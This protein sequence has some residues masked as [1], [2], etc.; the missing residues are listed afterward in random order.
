MT[1]EVS[2][3]PGKVGLPATQTAWAKVNLTLHVTGQRPDGYHLLDSLVVRLGI[4]D[5]L[6]VHADPVLK[7]EVDGP[8]AAG[9]PTDAR[10]LVVRAAQLLDGGTGRGA[11]VHLTKHLPA[12]AGIGGG[13]ADAAATLLALARHWGL[14]LP[15]DATVLGADV[16]VCL[17]QGPQRMQGVGEILSPLPAL[18]ACHMVLV[19]PGVSLPT[20]QVFAALADKV[21]PPMPDAIP[22]FADAARLADW[23]ATQRNDLQEPAVQLMPVI[24]QVLAG[25]EDALLARMSGSG[26]TCFGLYPSVAAAQAAAARIS[27][28]HPDWWVA[29]A[30]VLS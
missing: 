21:N 22:T 16:P 27:A 19:N 12:A 4:G 25:L 18:P 2:G 14:P 15:D 7:L 17:S 24:A 11:L 30:P 1:A 5:R 29:A 8:R 23:L 28:K 20:P 6:Q 3:D 13:S 26:A 9:V 10:N